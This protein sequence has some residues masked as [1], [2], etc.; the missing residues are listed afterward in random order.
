MDEGTSIKAYTLAGGALF[1]G[2][3]GAVE[4]VIEAGADAL[5]PAT[6]AD[7]Y[8]QTMGERTAEGAG[9]GL[10]IAVAILLCAFAYNEFSR[11]SNR[12]P[13]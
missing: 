6:P 8:W 13:S 12:R 3:A 7:A 1:G 2:V 10:A 5:N 9:V 4:G 11:M